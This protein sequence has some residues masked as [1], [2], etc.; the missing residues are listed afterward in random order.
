MCLHSICRDRWGI[1]FFTPAKWLFKAI[2]FIVLIALIKAWKIS[3]EGRK[4]WVT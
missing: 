3:S 1:N 2:Y 4:E